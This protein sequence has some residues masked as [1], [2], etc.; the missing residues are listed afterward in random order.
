MQSLFLWL[1]RERE[2]ERMF[3]QEDDFSTLFAFVVTNIQLLFKY[4]ILQY[5]SV[6]ISIK[7]LQGILGR[8]NYIIDNF[9]LDF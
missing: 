2:R 6:S 4:F 7:T 9:S 8:K 1:E 3:G 5:F